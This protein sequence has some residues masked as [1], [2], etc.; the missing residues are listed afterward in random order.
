M[1]L[2]VNGTGKDIADGATIVGLLGGLGL[3]DDRV[4]VE[5]NRVIIQRDNYADVMLKDGDVLEI[6]GFVGGG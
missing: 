2:I 6:V 3:S 1:K 5:L 4:A